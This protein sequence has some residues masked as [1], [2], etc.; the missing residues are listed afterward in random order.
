MHFLYRLTNSCLPSYS[1]PST[2]PVKFVCTILYSLCGLKSFCIWGIALYGSK[3]WTARKI[4]QKC[5]GSFEMW[6]WRRKQKMGWSGHVR[7]E[8]GLHR[9][10]EEWTILHKIKRKRANWTGYFLSGRCLHKV[11]IEGNRRDERRGRRCKPLMYNLTE[12]RP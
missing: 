8:G 3:I 11:A 6:C 12:S 1:F 9:F 2:F 10:K 7:N 4:D 5:T